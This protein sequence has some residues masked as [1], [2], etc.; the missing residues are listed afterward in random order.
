[1]YAKL[2]RSITMSSIWSED[3]DTRILWTTMLAEADSE[4]F[5]FGAL[6]GLANV[7]RLSMAETRAALAK[8]M[9]PDPESGDLTRNP[10]NEGRRVR[11]VA[12][13]WQLINYVHYRN[14]HDQEVR[15]AQYREAKRRARSSV[16]SPQMS[17]D[18]HTGPRASTD[19]H[20]SDAATDAATDAAKKQLNSDAVRD[21][22]DLSGRAAG[23]PA[24]RSAP[25]KASADPE[26][27]RS[28]QR[29]FDH[30]RTLFGKRD[31][32]SLTLER[33]RKI[34]ARLAE[35][36][37][38]ACITAITRASEDAWFRD[39]C[40]SNGIESIFRSQNKAEEWASKRAKGEPSSRGDCDDGWMAAANEEYRR[41]TAPEP[42]PEEPTDD[43]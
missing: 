24:K 26:V 29:I 31:P 41:L 22:S 35:L 9:A 4:G 28:I 8:L 36:G 32:Y 30:Y 34:A 19:V 6:P 37:E 11:E 14:I 12:G 3:K 1:M 17:T 25:K 13:G 21:P 15:R 18:V 42:D 2:F 33:R 39:V 27:G 38:D 5:I 7:A 43:L 20:P 40:S 23:D 10:A 16:D